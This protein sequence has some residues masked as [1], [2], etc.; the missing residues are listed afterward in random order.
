MWSRH[1]AP[2]RTS[3]RECGERERKGKREN[4]DKGQRERKAKREREREGTRI[5]GSAKWRRWQ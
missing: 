3:A 2:R 5:C 4:E 1:P